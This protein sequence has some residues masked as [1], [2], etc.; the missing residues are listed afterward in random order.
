MTNA[1][2]LQ[3]L[4]TPDLVEIK[5]LLDHNLDDTSVTTWAL[6]I[7]E[8]AQRAG[9][10]PM[11]EDE[12]AGKWVTVQGRPVYVGKARGGPGRAGSGPSVRV[13]ITSFRE[14]KGQAMEQLKKD[15]ASLED[16]LEATPV[17]DVSV[18][19]GTGGWEGGSEPTFVTQYRGNGAAK[20]VLAE[21][22]KEWNQDGVILVEQVKKGGTPESRLNFSEPLNEGQMRKAEQALLAAS[23]RHG[24]GIGG[25]TWANNGG[26]GPEL[27]TDCIPQ[28]GGNPDS[29]AAAVKETMS[30]LKEMGLGSS[31][32]ESRVK[33]ETWSRDEGDYDRVIKGD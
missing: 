4:S 31:Y 11:N 7:K 3:H 32:S 9:V 17:Q 1:P 8:V 26:K 13:G 25:W 27:I 12:K 18:S 24:A 10:W 29:H 28:W 33:V 14:T 15:M 19:L 20:K 6:V 5:S 2:L 21:K 23:E 16:D 22:A 30:M